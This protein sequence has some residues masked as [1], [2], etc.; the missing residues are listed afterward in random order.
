MCNATFAY[1]FVPEEVVSD[2]MLAIKMC[3]PYIMVNYVVYPIYNGQ[4]C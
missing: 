4:L 2:V 1:T 3:I